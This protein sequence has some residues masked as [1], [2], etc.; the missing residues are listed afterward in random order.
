MPVREFDQDQGM[1]YGVSFDSVAG[2]VRDDCVVRTTPEPPSGVAG[3]EVIFKLRQITSSSALMKELNISASASLRATFGKVSA[4]ASYASKQNVNQFSIYLLVQVSVTNPMRRMRDIKLTD[5]AWD[6]LEKNG[7]EQF[8]ERCGDEFLSG[9]T[10]GGEYLAILQIATKTEKDKEEVSVSVR[11]KGAGGTWKAGAD[12]KYALETIA[13]EHEIEVTSFQQGGDTKTIPDTVDE[14]IK[15]AV[16]FPQ[17]VEGDKAFAYSAFFQKYDTL[18]L[19]DGKNPIDVEN[20]KRVIEKL[21]DYYLSY[22]DILN[23]IEYIFKNSDQFVDFDVK[24][25]NQEANEIRKTLNELSQS[26][27]DCFNNYKSCKLPGSLRS[28]IVV[29]PARK[30]IKGGDIKNTVL[31]IAPF[32]GK[33]FGSEISRQ[34]VSAGDGWRGWSWDGKTASYLAVNSSGETVLYIVPFDGETFGSEISRQVVSAGDG[35][36]GWSWDGKTASYLAVNSSGETVLYI[37]S[38]DGETFGSEISQVV[39]AGDGWRGWSWDGKTASY[40][41]VN[42]SRK[43]VLHMAP[44]DGKTFGSEISQVVSA[45]DGWRGWSWDGKTASYLAWG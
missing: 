6:L 44:F 18:R 39:S 38:F 32:D 8:R 33:T 45:G 5:E 3:Q 34:V 28:P 27:S 12:F 11:A 10:T 42:F 41:A 15:R 14:I 16:E 19:P 23:S 35:W 1:A 24:A 36:R 4:K 22:S 25:M 40:L 7:E 43:T 21:A 26:A 31:Y 9:I 2:E 37:V 30:T 17:Q 29:L 13:Q 20:Q